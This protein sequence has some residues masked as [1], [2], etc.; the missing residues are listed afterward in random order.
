MRKGEKKP[1]T[2]VNIIRPFALLSLFF[3]FFLIICSSIAV[4]VVVVFFWW[5]RDYSDKPGVEETTLT[6][7]KK[8]ENNAVLSVRCQEG[9][10]CPLRDDM[11][12][13]CSESSFRI[14]V[15]AAA[16]QQLCRAAGLDKSRDLH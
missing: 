4:T 15:P 13:L 10:H 9:G 2:I 3:F 6:I 12:A 14:D 11:A 7:N 1:K 8:K 16:T 5:G